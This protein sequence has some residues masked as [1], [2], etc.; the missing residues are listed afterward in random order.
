MG[1]LK[2]FH[3]K[4]NNLFLSGGGDIEDTIMLD[5]EFFLRL[6]DGAK[7]LYVPIAMDENQISYDACSDWFT[8]LISKHCIDKEVDYRLWVEKEHVPDMD[9]FDAVYIG[10]GNT[11]Y[12]LKTFRDLGIDVSLRSFIENGGLVYGGSAGAIIMGKSIATVHEEN[13]I[14]LSYDTGLGLLGNFSLRCHF[15][16]A[17]VPLLKQR[18]LDLGQSIIA[19]P[20]PSGIVV[21]ESAFT[22]FGDPVTLFVGGEKTEIQKSFNYG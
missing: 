8:K 5:G 1:L 6:P 12:L 21:G 19:I 14:D 15:T 16:D 4:K 13:T 2:T 11:Y 18:S 17:D 20:E 3:M 7:I 22:V 9:M 10:G